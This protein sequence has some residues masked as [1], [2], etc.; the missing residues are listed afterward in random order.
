VTTLVYALPSVEVPPGGVVHAECV[1]QEPFELE[2]FRA[3]GDGLE[4]VRVSL[5][6]SMRY[7]L[8]QG[9][10]ESIPLALFASSSRDAQPLVLECSR[11]GAPVEDQ[12]KR[13]THCAAPF[14]WRP[15]T[16]LAYAGGAI[17]VEASLLPGH[18]LTATFENLGTRPAFVEAAFVGKRREKP[19]TWLVPVP[20]RGRERIA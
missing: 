1:V 10:G 5:V 17:R 2:E 11:C 16:E 14:T 19:K 13:C 4:R 15:M 12:A 9:T 6:T 8:A 3:F 7:R 20:P 18:T